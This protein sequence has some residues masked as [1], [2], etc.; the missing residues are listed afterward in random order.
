MQ[1]QKVKKREDQDKTLA[2]PKGIEFYDDA[3]RERLD[4]KKAKLDV[5]R[6]DTSKP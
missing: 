5:K 1:A 3:T 6:W 2:Y 4:K